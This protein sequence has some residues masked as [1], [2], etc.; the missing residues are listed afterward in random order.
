MALR[1][2]L[3][4][5]AI[6]LVVLLG[7][8]LLAGDVSAANHHGQN[9]GGDF[10]S[11]EVEF[12]AGNW[13]ARILQLL[14]PV[15][16]DTDLGVAPDEQL[17]G[18]GL[19]GETVRLTNGNCFVSRSDVFLASAHSLGLS[20]STYYNSQSALAGPLGAGWCHTYGIF[21][22]PSFKFRSKT[23]V[24]IVD[25]TGRGHYFRKNNNGVLKGAFQE[26]SHVTAEAD[27][28]VWH[29]LDGSR[30]GF[31]AT[32]R[33]LWID[34]EKGNRLRLDYD[35]QDRLDT[36][37][38]LASGRTLAFN[39]NEEGL[40]ASIAGPVTAMVAD[41]IW[42][43]F[44]YDAEGN[45]V[46]VTYADDTGFE[47]TYADGQD[48]HNLTAA[49]NKAGH[50]I[51]TWT[52]DDQDR[53][54]ANFNPQGRGVAVNYDGSRRVVVTDAY[55]VSRTYV[56]KIIKGRKRLS[57]MHGPAG[58]PYTDTPV[59]EWRY[60]NRLRLVRVKHANGAVHK[61]RNYDQRGNP[62]LI[63]LAAGT[64][65][66]HDIH[67]AH[68][69]RMNA[70]LSRTEASVLGT[71]NKTTIFDFDDDGNDAPNENP[72]GLLYRIIGKGF[73]RN[74]AGD[75]TP[76]EYITR[77]AYNDRGQVISVDGPQPGSDDTTELSYASTSADL[78]E[79]IRPLIGATSFLEYD[80]AGHP[81]KIIDVNGQS[82]RFSYDGRGRVIATFQDADQS[83][84]S[85]SYNAAGLADTITD[86]DEVYKTYEYYPD[87]A[88][89][90]RIYDFDNNYIHH[91]YDTRGNLIE[92]SRHDPTGD[93][94]SRSRWSY[95]SPDIPGKLYRA[96]NFDDTYTEY[97]YDEAGNLAS[98]TDPETNTIQYLYDVFN[99]IKDVIQTT[100][101]PGDVVTSYDYD[102]H[103][104]LRSVTDAEHHQT[105][106]EYDDMG[107]VVTTLS[108]DTGTTRYAY[109]EAGN[110]VG[111]TD[112]NGVTTTYRYDV[113]NRLTAVVFPDAT[114]SITY[115]YDQGPFGKGRRTGM[116]DPSGSTTFGYSSRGR[117]VSKTSN[118]NRIAYQL[119]RDFSPAGRLNSI[120]YPS[121][122]SINL[123]RYDSG[124]IKDIAT[125]FNADVTPLVGNMVYNPFGRPAGM[126]TGAGGVINNRSSECACLEVANP[127]SFMEQQYI[128]DANRNLVSIVGTN[129]PWFNQDFVYDSL[130]RLKQAVGS[131]GTIDYTYDKVGNRLTR[132][133]DAETETYTY[134]PGTNRLQ[135][136]SGA[137][138]VAYEYDPNGNTTAIG[139]KTLI[140][141]QNNRLIK[142]KKNADLIG[143]YVYNGSGQR[144][145]KTAA[146]RTTVFLYDF[147]GNIITEGHPDGTL[148]SEYLYMFGNRIARVEI[149]TGAFYYFLNNYLGTPFLM[150]SDKGEVVWEA[151]Y[152]PFGEVEVGRKSTM[153]NNFRFPG[154]YYDE[155]IGLYYNFHRYYYPNFGRYLTPDPIGYLGGVNLYVYASNNAVNFIDFHGLVHWPA[156][157][158]GTAKVVFGF[159]A[160]AG[161]AVAASTPTGIGQVV[162]VAGALAGSSSIGF[163][164]SQIITGF[165]DNEISFMGV[166]EAV[167]Q[168]TTSGLTQKNLL[169]A[170]E[171]LDM[172]PG[173]VSGT[174]RVD[175]T[176]LEEILSLIEYSLSIGKS[177]NQIQQELV[178]AGVVIPDD[179]E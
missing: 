139:D 161:G 164:V 68:H 128:Y 177:V 111:K 47:Y 28:F 99:R 1:G 115:S 156:V 121:G 147:D 169:A 166:K 108:P 117:L 5:L 95:D 143:E 112:A 56:L 88:R 100:D 11:P 96:I 158:K 84:S 132:T 94:Y 27:G 55:G 31:D 38:D 173:I 10:E 73:T 159:A 20:F 42:T 113:L 134:Y 8:P 119:N 29:R 43:A 66:Q 69:P 49:H 131:Y 150:T 24:R 4:G 85:I 51:N 136:V 135:G 133:I 25:A 54:V 160:V 140:Y 32:G 13:G 75:I 110:L 67:L 144:V 58:P 103:G 6:V 172:I 16:A 45:P 141:N 46:S 36:V 22:N 102:A 127:G 130:Q 77:F 40:V 153:V 50:L 98:M 30:C 163:G 105:L 118:V 174:L 155:E 146:G 71:G 93:R 157:A 82:T 61:Y 154:Q 33:L 142:V 124:K 151:T 44:D 116:T 62:R 165:A 167:I 104:N 19:V 21:L 176:K 123:T 41:G 39:Y 137:Q 37:T 171:L 92:R 170:N 76:Y 52:Y 106:Y 74:P 89:I 2:V 148:S 126:T 80:A 64:D 23:Y 15:P 53:C 7:C 81:G 179:C 59:V 9:G 129:T 145:T 138:T 90:Y 14:H 34:D 175:P 70:L 86:E 107:R 17:G 60:D 152:R 122:R 87:H 26:R 91:D 57:A 162:G 101:S 178:E 114:Q 125:A 18:G 65:K 78:N 149:D 97:R 83:T 48:A 63:V 72:T 35:G 79:I 3:P 109:D 168:G 12:L 120:T